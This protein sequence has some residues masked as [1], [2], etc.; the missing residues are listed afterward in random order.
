MP[1]LHAPSP[2]G[3]AQ[4][5][6]AVDDLLASSHIA[7]MTPI[8]HW[9]WALS[10]PVSSE[11]RIVPDMLG[12]ASDWALESTPTSLNTHRSA[13]VIHWAERKD[14][15]HDRW[16]L[17]LATLPRHVQS[18]L[19]PEK[20][21]LLLEEML[22]AAGSTDVNLVQCLRDGFPLIDKLPR[23]GTVPSVPYSDPP[24]SLASLQLPG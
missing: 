11:E 16:R 13:A 15:L 20:N 23:S 21:L 24:E 17:E 4:V 8:E 14:A 6:Q 5:K 19:G 1:T 7:T 22:T 12:T 2:S 9:E 10:L 18:V 3:L